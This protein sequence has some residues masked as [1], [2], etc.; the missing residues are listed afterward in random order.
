M[1]LMKWFMWLKKF[2]NIW[3]SFPKR[4]LRFIPI[5]VVLIGVFIFLFVDKNY[6]PKK[7]D[8]LG[9][10]L[11]IIGVILSLI[12]WPSSFAETKTQIPIQNTNFVAYPLNL[13]EQWN[14]FL[15]HLDPGFRR[16][17]L[18]YQPFVV[19]G[20]GDSN[21]TCLI[22][23]YSGWE[24]VSLQFS[25][26]NWGNQVLQI[27]LGQKSVIEEISHLLLDDTSRRAREALQDLWEPFVAER[28]PLVLAAVA[29]DPEK[30]E[31][32]LEKEGVRIRG[33][34]DI[35]SS[36]TQQPVATRV[37]FTGMENINGYEQF[38]YF[39]QS[40]HAPMQISLPTKNITDKE[41]QDAIIA[42][43]EYL[44]NALIDM[45]TEDYEKIVY[46]LNSLSES[47]TNFL[48]FLQALTAPA[49]SYPL[50]SL[51]VFFTSD[52]KDDYAAQPFECEWPSEKL[53]SETIHKYRFRYLLIGIA[54]VL[55][56]TL[57]LFFDL[58]KIN[59]SNVK[60][61]VAKVLQF[62][63]DKLHFPENFDDTVSDLKSIISTLGKNKELWG[64]V[65]KIADSP[66]MQ[67][68]ISQLPQSVQKGIKELQQVGKF[69]SQNKE[70]IETYVALVEKILNVVEQHEIPYQL[71]KKAVFSFYI[72]K[73]SDELTKLQESIDPSEKEVSKFLFQIIEWLYKKSLTDLEKQLNQVWQGGT[74]SLEQQVN[75]LLTLYPFSKT[76][77]NNATAENI[78]QLFQPQ[79]G[80]FYQFS[81]DLLQNVT[82]VDKNNNIQPKTIFATTIKIAASILKTADQF[83]NISE[84]L[85]DE[86]GKIQPIAFS[87]TPKSLPENTKIQLFLDA[88]V[89]PLELSQINLALNWPGNSSKLVATAT[90]D[91]QEKTQILA[92]QQQFVTSPW[93]FFHL[94][95]EGTITN[96]I[97]ELADIQLKFEISPETLN[98]LQIFSTSP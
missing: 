40:I 64:I 25:P 17:V 42:W 19:L 22:K 1:Q 28:Q 24:Q 56:A 61:E 5:A 16:V 58:P 78:N 4:I 3:R 75:N 90:V 57:P 82:Y 10:L 67:E 84:I 89:T 62:A 74:P 76:A 36:I 13:R 73:Y 45:S 12:K 32:S 14:N 33:K 66:K 72:L 59:V 26:N 41:L 96:N 97:W 71:D 65:N 23:R 49:I 95:D 29:Y 39:M 85:W 38:A 87:F 88:K 43:E 63:E 27:Y 6:L 37:V 15:L 54:I 53:V 91:G 20:E 50:A 94:L 8:D 68:I 31:D 44:P 9:I 93:S 77:I 60:E 11:I 46:F 18:L 34:I 47:I 86:Q 35:L 55:I 21:K 98:V 30:D 83:S 51:D 52:L 79:I 80:K 48:P 81:T 69:I 70:K 7:Y 2:Y 92:P